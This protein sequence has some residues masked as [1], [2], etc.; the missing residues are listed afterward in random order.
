[1]NRAVERAL[2]KIHAFSADTDEHLE[3]ALLRSGAKVV[4]QLVHT[5]FSPGDLEAGRPRRSV[6]V[7]L[8][9]NT[10]LMLA[11]GTAVVAHR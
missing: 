11:D 7:V 9:D 6:M 4:A 2:G 3:V 10:H 1:M 5:D 8:V